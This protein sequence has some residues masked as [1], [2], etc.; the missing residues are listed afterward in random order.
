MQ[1]FQLRVPGLSFQ[2]LVGRQF[3]AQA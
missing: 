2:Q 3:G 1:V